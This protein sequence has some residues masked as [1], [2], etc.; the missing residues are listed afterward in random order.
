MCHLWHFS[1]IVS[2]KFQQ[3]NENEN[4]IFLFLQFSS[5]IETKFESSQMLSK[6]SHKVY[7]VRD[8]VKKFLNLIRSYFQSFAI[9]NQTRDE[10]LILLRVLGIYSCSTITFSF[11]SLN[12]YYNSP[13][14]TP[15]SSTLTLRFQTAKWQ[16]SEKKNTS[17]KLATFYFVQHTQ[18]NLFGERI[19]A[20][21]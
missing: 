2:N 16:L 18:L 13:L 4:W 11:G 19:T 20:G 10:I 6:T 9:F 1:R 8:T 21:T 12:F 14:P 15:H 3:I 17:V 7:I 5:V